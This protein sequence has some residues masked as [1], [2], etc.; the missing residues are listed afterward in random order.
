MFKYSF[1]RAKFD[2]MTET[3]TWHFLDGLD[4]KTAQLDGKQH[5]FIENNT[6]QRKT[7]LFVLKRHCFVVNDRVCT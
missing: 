3:G 1:D 4:I 5:Y 6:V 7:A 2:K